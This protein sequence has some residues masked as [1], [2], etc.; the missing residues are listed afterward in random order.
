[1]LI[2]RDRSSRIARSPAGHTKHRGLA[3][4]VLVAAC[5]LAGGVAMAAVSLPFTDGFNRSNGPLGSPWSN[6]GGWAI[7]SGR[8]KLTSNGRAETVVDTGRSDAYRVSAQIS[9]S[10][11]RANAGLSTLWKSHSNHLFCK[12]EVTPGNPRG[13]MSIGHQLNGRNKSL[14][15]SASGFGLDAG[16]TYQL[17]VTKQ[18]RAISCA[19]SGPGINGGTKTI[20]YTLSNEEASA[21]G[22][23]TRSGF[24]GKNLFDEDDGQTRY[25]DF[26]VRA[27]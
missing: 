20:S 9:L 13:L 1:M 8:V 4:A 18:G 5:L 24:R 12:I 17:T 11:R 19:V 27:I 3:I 7:D 23:A 6:T 14:L 16:K 26:A 10:P 2:R 22:S 25:D 21:F 15:R